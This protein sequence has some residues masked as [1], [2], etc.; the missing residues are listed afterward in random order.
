MSEDEKDGEYLPMARV[1]RS[2]KTR[3]LRPPTCWTSH[4][5]MAIIADPRPLELVVLDVHVTL[6]HVHYLMCAR[7][8]LLARVLAHRRKKTLARLLQLSEPYLH[9]VLSTLNA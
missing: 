4:V 3:I 5:V 7:C 8:S 2:R 9:P 6:I 1:L